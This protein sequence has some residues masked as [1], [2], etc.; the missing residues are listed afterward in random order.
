MKNWEWIKKG[1][2]IRV[3]LGPRDLEKNSVAVSRRDQ[4]VKDKAVHGNERNS[5]PAPS[6][7]LGSIQQNLYQ[8]ALKFRDANTRTIDTKE[9]FYAFFTPKNPPNR[10]F[11]AALLSRTGMARAKSRKKSKDDLKVTIR[12]IPS[13]DSEPGRCIFTGEPSK[14]R[15]VW[16]KAY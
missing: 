6:E 16:S 11:M 13:S 7:I 1:V 15:V 4:P 2:P 8:R 14:K 5:F 10:K 3:E 12:C 9:E